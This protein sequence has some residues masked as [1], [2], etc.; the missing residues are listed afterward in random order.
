[1]S[2]N[3]T[4]DGLRERLLKMEQVTPSLKQR[5]ERE[6]QDMLEKKLTGV[7]LW[8]WLVSAIAGL[9]FA[10]LFSTLA[11]MMPTGFPWPG[12]LG[13]A[14]SAL[15]GIGWAILGIRVF[16]NGS[17]DLKI[18]TGAAAGMSWVLP[19]FL[20]TL[21]MVWAPDSITGLRMIVSSLAFLIMGAVFLIRHVIEQSE[22]NAREKLLEIEYR[23]AELTEAMKLGRPRPPTPQ[24]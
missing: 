8:A 4:H 10:V 12:R 11:V 16:R 15:F 9:A 21:F 5:Y 3:P 2:M 18:D 1:M 13:F 22:L 20:V 24:A 19:V 23:L 6:I 14:G 17:L 7:R